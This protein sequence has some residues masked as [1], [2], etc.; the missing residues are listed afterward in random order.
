MNKKSNK[1]LAIFIIILGIFIVIG[2]WPSQT[3]NDSKETVLH[4]KPT[5]RST[6]HFT[7]RTNGKTTRRGQ[8]I[9]MENI[10]TIT[11]I[12]VII[13]MEMALNGGMQHPRIWCNGKMKGWPF[14]NILTEMVI[15]GRDQSLWTIQIRL[16]LE[17]GLLWRS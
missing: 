1:W 10:I 12:M 9:W 7:T 15:H 14:L 11:F 4:H 8:F 2:L 5:Y 6:Y 17:K 16:A 13:R 3:E